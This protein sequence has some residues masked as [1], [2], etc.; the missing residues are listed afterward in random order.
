VKFPAIVD[1]ET[2]QRAQDTLKKNFLF[3]MRNTRGR[4]T[5]PCMLDAQAQL[6]QTRS[7]YG[8]RV[9]RM[10]N[11]KFFFSVSCRSFC[12]DLPHQQDRGTSRVSLPATT[13]FR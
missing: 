5:D 11:R 10:A 8:R 1:A 9:L 4:V 7:E 2:W 12:L 6:Y 13:L 3:A